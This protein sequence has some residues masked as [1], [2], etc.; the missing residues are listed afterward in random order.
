MNPFMLAFVLLFVCG[1]SGFRRVEQETEA[2]VEMLGRYNGKKLQP[3]LRYVIPILEQKVFHETKREKVIDIPPQKCFTKDNVAVTVDAV[4]Y[5]R[6]VDMEKAYYRVENLKDAMVNLVLTQVRSEMGKLELDQTFSA[7]AEVNEI[8]LQELDV[9]TDPWGVKI[10]RVELRDL[11]PSSAV[12]DSMEL[13]MSAE[14]KKRAAI[15]TSEGERESAVNHARGKAEAQVL[16]AQA[17]QKA[18]ILE[19][20]AER[21]AIALKAEGEKQREILRAQ[22]T[23]EAMKTITQTIASYPHAHQSLQ[24]L[25]TQGYL[26]MGAQIGSSESSKVMFFDPNSIMST[27]EGMRSL[28]SERNQP[29]GENHKANSDRS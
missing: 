7:R 17:K 15:L 20:E 24:Y 16:E 22:A 11:L 9:A 8:L 1:L 5:W 12:Q 14:R 25:L 23:A 4:V 2:I 28:V 21:K 29:I 13:Q 6:I 10:T 19:A 3:G 26:Q 18:K 27:F